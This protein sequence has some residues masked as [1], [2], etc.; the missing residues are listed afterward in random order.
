MNCIAAA[1]LLLK[2]WQNAYRCNL[3][4]NSVDL[5]IAVAPERFLS[6]TYRVLAHEHRAY[7]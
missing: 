6:I 3:S 7:K 1:K 5:S 2:N 4:C